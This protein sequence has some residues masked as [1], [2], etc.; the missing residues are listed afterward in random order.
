[1]FYHFK[2][3]LKACCF[4]TVWQKYEVKIETKGVK[5]ILEGFLAKKRGL[6]EPEARKRLKTL[7]RA[8]E[9]LPISEVYR[10]VLSG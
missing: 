1:M 4:A 6:M 9:H 8:S 3:G 10:Q 7:F 2:S 5:S